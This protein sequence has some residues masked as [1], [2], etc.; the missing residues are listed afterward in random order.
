MRSTQGLPLLALALAAA[1]LLSSGASAFLL[2]ASHAP[3]ATT[4]S[5]P[6]ARSRVAMEVAAGANSGI[7]SGRSS[8]RRGLLEDAGKVGLLTLG[9]VGG[10]RYVS[11]ASRSRLN[12]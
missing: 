7:S 6:A 11:D 9:L 12:A 8:S 1:A 10:V 4:A 5:S 2:P 3:R